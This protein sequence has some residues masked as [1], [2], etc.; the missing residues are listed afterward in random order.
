MAPPTITPSR[1]RATR[2]VAVPRSMTMQGQEYRAF[3]P[4]HPAITIGARGFWLINGN[5]QKFLYG[6]IAD[7]KGLD[8]KELSTP[9]ER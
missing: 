1:S 2:V 9:W 7:D 3:A 6:L 5:G 4:A 8:R